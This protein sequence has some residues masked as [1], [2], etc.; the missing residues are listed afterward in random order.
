MFVLLIISL[1]TNQSVKIN[2][3]SFKNSNNVYLSVFL[4]GKLHINLNEV[5]RCPVN[6]LEGGTDTQYVYIQNIL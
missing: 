4:H 5:Q 1:Q 6:C 3:Q 2:N